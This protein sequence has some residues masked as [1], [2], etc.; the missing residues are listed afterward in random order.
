MNDVKA[1]LVAALSNRYRIERELGAGG[2]ATLQLAEGLENDRQ[3]VP[4]LA[5]VY[6]MDVRFTPCPGPAET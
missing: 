3:V 5:T 2:M 4:R 6:P 1:R